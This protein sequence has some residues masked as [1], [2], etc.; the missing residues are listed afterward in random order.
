[1]NA[2][3]GKWNLRAFEHY[4]YRFSDNLKRVDKTNGDPF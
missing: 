2:L 4:E 3:I 1:M